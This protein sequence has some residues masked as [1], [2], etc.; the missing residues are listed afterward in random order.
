MRIVIDNEAGFCFGVSNAISIAGIVLEEGGTLYSLGELVHNQQ[1]IQRLHDKGMKVIDSEQFELL[2][3]CKVL[4]RAHGEPLQTYLSAEKNDIQLIDATCPIVRH[5]Q[6]KIRNK[7]EQVR[8]ERGQIVIFGKTNHPEVIG[9]IGQVNGEAI[10]VLTPEDIQMIDPD[11]NVYLYA[12]TTMD[13]AGYE[14]I[15][16]LISEHLGADDTKDLSKLY[17]HNTICRQVTQRIENLKQFA[18]DHEIIVFVSGKNSS[19]G[20]FLYST[21][22]KVNPT[23]YLISNINEID[24][25]WF[26]DVSSVGISGATSTP[27]S[28][29]VEVSEFLRSHI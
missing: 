16:R 12:Q 29:L 20:R 17:Q 1:E 21:C 24:H 7:Y 14:I 28:Q 26:K 10:V 11:R 4:I 5:L 25:T 8:E 23:T 15:T 3:D 22:K 19:N 27:L 18:R 2:H 13:P 9:L 6:R